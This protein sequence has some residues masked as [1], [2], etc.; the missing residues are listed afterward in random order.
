MDNRIVRQPSSESTP[1]YGGELAFTAMLVIVSIILMVALPQ[2]VQAESLFRA[3]ARYQAPPMARS[4]FT[5]PISNRVGDLITIN[6]NENSAITTDAELSVTRSQTINENGTS[7][8]NDVI[9]FFLNKLPFSTGTVQQALQLPSFTGLNNANTLG[10]EAESSRNNIYT[11][12]I[13]CQVTQIL[14]NG[15]LMVQGQKVMM[16]NKE[17]STLIVTGIVRP[18]YLN[19][20]N[21]IDSNRVGNFQ[22]IQGGKGVISRQQNDGIA[23]KIYQFFN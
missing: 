23:N 13:T 16:A 7:L 19:Q 21:E 4:L 14:P 20:F 10:S 2:M 3:S 12:R 22:L 9:G 18:Y 8:F 11:D 6:V 17:Q 5:P 1:Y 15:D